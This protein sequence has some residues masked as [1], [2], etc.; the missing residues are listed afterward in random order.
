MEK[1]NIQNGSAGCALPFCIA[2]GDNGMH[3]YSYLEKN[4]LQEILAQPTA[5]KQV[6]IIHLEMVRESRS[7]YGMARLSSPKEAA[8]LAAPMFKRMDREMMVVLSMDSRLEPVALE[9]AAVGGLNCCSVDVANLFK[10]A[11]LNN[12]A[13]I[14]CF[15]NHPSGDCEPSREDMAMTKRLVEC[16]KLLGIPLVDHIIIGQEGAYL[17]FAE[18]GWLK[19]DGAA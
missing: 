15:H 11:I 7:L 3:G 19:G 17:S 16:G 12:S 10:H 4:A 1:K 9:V 2:E 6:G 13:S 18:Q 5:K 8:E 14:I